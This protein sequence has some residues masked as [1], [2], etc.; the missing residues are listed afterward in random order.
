MTMYEVGTIMKYRRLLIISHN[1]FSKT[2][3]N[4][5]TLANY[6]QGWPKD[7]LAQFYL[8][9]ENPDFDIC[10]Q[11]YCMTDVS[12]AKS[13]LN[14]KSAGYVVKNARIAND[15]F[16]ASSTPKKARMKNSIAFS[17]RE[18]AWNSYFWNSSGFDNWLNKFS[19]EVVLVQAGDSGF[20]FDLAV[21]ISRRFNATIVVYNTEGYYFKK[22]SYLS[23]NCV[24]KF[25]YPALNR[26]FKKSY[27]RLVKESQAQIYNCD[28]LR[29][30]YERVFHTG[31]RVIMNTSEFT[32]E[33]V[34]SPKKNQII[35]AGNLGLFRH[36]SLIEFANALQRV[37]PDM[38]VDVYGKS[39][40]EES[41]QELES[42]SGIRLHGFI[43]YEELKQK[44]RESKYLLHIESFEPF[45]RE[46]LKYA[47]STKIADSL[48]AG[49]CMFVYAPENMAV[50]Q[51]LK[52]KNAAVLIMQQEELEYEI[53]RVLS[54]EEVSDTYARNGRALAKK[55]HNIQKNRAA[56][57]SVLL[58]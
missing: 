41:K 31:S 3:S 26:R 48:A 23:E 56:F 51:Y 29:D 16:E 19:P 40:D 36:K 4:G 46:D 53:E 5:R 32:D 24:S 27:D 28:S 34:F 8:H 52:D 13:I 58:E 50:C 38:Y 21:S 15:E 44:L 35:Y 45:Y 1:C 57:Q 6:L 14:R 37:N 22:M 12:I 11:Y 30:D 54:N 18:A 7:E 10:N 9:A 39:P 25:F 20:L 49:A 42:C 17:L 43:S 33:D 47:F 2:G 55:N